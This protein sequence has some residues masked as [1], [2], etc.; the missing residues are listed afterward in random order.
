MFK[1]CLKLQS[2]SVAK[3]RLGSSFPISQSDTLLTPLTPKKQQERSKQWQP[4]TFPVYKAF[5][6]SD[7]LRFVVPSALGPHAS[8]FIWN[9]QLSPNPTPTNT[10]Q[11]PGLYAFSL[12]WNIIPL[13]KL[14]VTSLRLEPL[15]CAP[16]LFLYY[17]H[18]PQPTLGSFYLIIF[19]PL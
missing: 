8:F 1:I 10:P 3:G 18:S 4:V 12:C 7:S 11:S 6:F 14:S 9:P 15:S 2:W 13:G 16:S 19:L 5:H 17:Y